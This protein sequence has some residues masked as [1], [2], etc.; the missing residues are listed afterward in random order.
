MNTKKEIKVGNQ[1]GTHLCTRVRV[2][3][4]IETTSKPNSSSPYAGGE[5]TNSEE[6]GYLN[7]KVWWTA[8]MTLLNSLKR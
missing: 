3:A 5:N 1:K 2:Q 4:S 6:F 8:E 7:L